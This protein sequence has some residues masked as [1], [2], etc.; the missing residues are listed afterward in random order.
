MQIVSR[1]REAF[2]ANLSLDSLFT[3]PMVAEMVITILQ[4]QADNLMAGDLT[5]MLADLH[6][7]SEEEAG[8]RLERELRRE[9]ISG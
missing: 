2:L 1:L 8:Q 9:S 6:M 7:L 5:S 4:H 3:S